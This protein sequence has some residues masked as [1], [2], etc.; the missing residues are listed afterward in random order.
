MAADTTDIDDIREQ[1]RR[2]LADDPD[3]ASRDELTA[4]LDAATA[5]PAAHPG[6]RVARHLGAVAGAMV[7]ASHNPPQANG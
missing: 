7:T 3:P 4:V 1:A 5:P 2:W 6:A